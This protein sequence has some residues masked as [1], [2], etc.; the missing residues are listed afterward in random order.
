MFDILVVDQQYFTPILNNISIAL[1]DDFVL[2]YVCV[3]LS[4]HSYVNTIT[5]CLQLHTNS[6][7]DLNWKQESFISKKVQDYHRCQ[8]QP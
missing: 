8:S 2:L 4:V 1:E 7:G 6:A 3:H 5:V